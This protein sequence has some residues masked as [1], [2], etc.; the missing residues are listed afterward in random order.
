MKQSESIAKLSTALFKAQYAITG[1][2][3]DST[4]PFFKSNYADLQSVWEAVKEPLFQNELSVLQPTG[5]LDGNFGVYTLLTHSSGEYV[6]GF[7]PVLSKDG[8][9][10]AQGSGIS[11]ARRYALASILGVYQVD[12]DGNR[13]EGHISQPQA[14]PASPVKPKNHAPQSGTPKQADPNKIGISEPQQKRLYAIGTK[15][16]YEWVPLCRMIGERYG[17]HDFTKFK[18]GDYQEFCTWLEANPNKPEE[19]LPF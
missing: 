2:V 7:T 9:P 1:A 19:E 13:A 8:S 12:D 3:K 18:Q 6:Q 5:I 17:V 15:S 16:G 14:S 4:N 11:Y 10:Q